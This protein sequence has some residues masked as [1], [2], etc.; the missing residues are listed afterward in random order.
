MPDKNST[1]SVWKFPVAPDEFVT[2]M[3]AG[4]KVLSVDTQHGG[5][6]MWVLVDP[7]APDAQRRFVTVGTGHTL[8]A[9]I[10]DAEFVGTFQLHDGALVFHLFDFG[11]V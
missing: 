1:R 2:T 4:A 5:A 6:Q 3:P 7:D 8:P 11:E 10:G 9:E